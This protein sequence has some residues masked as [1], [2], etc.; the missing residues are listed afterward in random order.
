MVRRR[1]SEHW[2][3]FVFSQRS[4]VFYRLPERFPWD[5]FR[6][7]FQLG[8]GDQLPGVYTRILPFDPLSFARLSRL[9]PSRAGFSTFNTAARWR[10]IRASLSAIDVN[11]VCR[12][13]HHVNECKCAISPSLHMEYIAAQLLGKPQWR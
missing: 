8:A 4:R 10:I 12:G 1:T 13:L 7:I 2:V 6:P 11:C 5:T 3:T 9:R